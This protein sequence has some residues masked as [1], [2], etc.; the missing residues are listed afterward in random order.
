MTNDSHGHEWSA[1]A[2]FAKAQLYAEQMENHATD[3]WQYGFWSALI[4]EFLGR[5][6]LAHVSPTLLA[7]HRNWRNLSHALQ[8][9]PTAKKFLPRSISAVE[10]FKRLNE[11]VPSFNHEMLS[12]CSQHAD[13]RNSE[14]HSGT[15]AFEALGTSEWLANFYT[16]CEAMLKTMGRDLSS[17]IHESQ[18]AESMIASLKDA[19]AE[20]VKN[21]IV[22]HRA[23][24]NNKTDDER[25]RAVDQ[26]KTWARRQVGHCVKCPSCCSPALVK[27]TPSGRVLR[28]TT[29]VN[30]VERQ[31]QSPA[32]FE[33]IACGLRI[34]GYSK[35]S[36]CGLGDAFTD[37]SVYPIADYYGLHTDEELEDARE[38][39]YEELYEYEPDFN[40]CPIDQEYFSMKRD[41]WQLSLPSQGIVK[42]ECL[43]GF[44]ESDTLSDSHWQRS[45]E[46]DLAHVWGS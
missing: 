7:D 21:D 15:L 45:S 23:V 26:A 33:C 6:S 22:A 20:K 19:S 38:Q 27:G 43:A 25:L 46:V 3:E 16:A 8:L 41:T 4:L 1:E 42:P 18:A 34:A 44:S 31:S 17:L 5:A 10:V 24:W 37:K 12:F 29:D 14:L 39:I 32:S 2:L 11:L 30:V 35:L 40:E 28:E 13:R 36:A 9:Q